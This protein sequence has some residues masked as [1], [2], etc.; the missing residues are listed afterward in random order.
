MW[1]VTSMLDVRSAHI[2]RERVS[3]RAR[4]ERRRLERQHELLELQ[5]CASQSKPRLQPV[6]TPCSRTRGGTAPVAK[7]T[8]RQG[9]EPSGTWRVDRGGVVC[10][11]VCSVCM[12]VLCVFVCVT[13]C[14]CVY[15]LHRV[16]SQRAVH[17]TACPRHAVRLP[18]RPLSA[19]HGRSVR[20]TVS[21]PSAHP[22]WA[23]VSPTP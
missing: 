5:R 23:S 10:V 6:S 20:T 8:G 18:E 17:C 21:I 7:P 4:L 22:E 16:A 12:C 14:L 1:S 9:G 11:C 19:Q 13:V 15:G 3:H 2:D